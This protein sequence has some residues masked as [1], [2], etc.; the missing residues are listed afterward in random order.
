MFFIP[1]SFLFREIPVTV[2]LPKVAKK[3]FLAAV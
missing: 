2:N 3:I 1:L